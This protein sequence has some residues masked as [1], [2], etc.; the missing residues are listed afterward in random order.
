MQPPKA[1]RQYTTSPHPTP[2]I[3]HPNKQ[4][5]SGCCATTSPKGEACSTPNPAAFG[6]GNKFLPPPLGEGRGGGCG[7]CPIQTLAAGSWPVRPLHPTSRAPKRTN[8]PSGNRHL[9][10]GGGRPVRLTK[11]QPAYQATDRGQVAP[12]A[13]RP[14]VAAGGLE[15]AAGVLDP[16]GPLGAPAGGVFG[17]VVGFPAPDVQ[18]VERAP[19]GAPG[20][21]LGWSRSSCSTSP[22]ALVRCQTSVSPPQKTR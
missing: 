16:D 5:P 12:E 11:R 21:S 18:L 9:P 17:F 20:A 13:G 7:R 6:S 15:A 8:P 10:Q 1:G 22:A 4:P 3:R 2:Y 19:E 14:G